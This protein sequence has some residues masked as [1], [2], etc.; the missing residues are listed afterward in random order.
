MHWGELQM[1]N[2]VQTLTSAQPQPLT[3]QK[4]CSCGGICPKCRHDRNDLQSIPGNVYEVLNTT[5]N[6]LDKNTR[7]FMESKFGQDFS[8]VKLHTDENAT[9][10]AQQMN[11]KAYTV[12]QNIVFDN[13]YYSPASH[14]GRHL[15]AHELTHTVQQKNSGSF[16]AEKL[17]VGEAHDPSEREAD[18]IADKIVG[19]DLTHMNVLENK[20]P[21]DIA[22]INK[23]PQQISKAPPETK[24][25]PAPAVPTNFTPEQAEML[26][27]TRAKLNPKEGGIVGVLIAEHPSSPFEFES[28]GGQGFS[29]HIEGKATAKMNELGI[30]KA[31]LVLELEPCQICDRSVYDP[32]KGPE[33]PLKSTSTG[34][35][36]SRQTPKINSAL[37]VGSELT[38]VGPESTGVYRGTAPAKPK[39][40]LPNLTES[41]RAP[42]TATEPEAEKV[43]KQRGTGSRRGGVL[44]PEI[45]A[46][47][48]KVPKIGGRGLGGRIAKGALK[49]AGNIVLDL[50]LLVATLVDELI[51]KPKLEALIKELEDARKARIQKKIEKI[52]Q[53]RIAAHIGK[54]LKVCYLKLLRELEKKGKQAYVN[55][56]L[57][58]ALE[59]TSNRFQLFT[60]TPPESFFDIEVD[61]VRYKDA[62]LSEKPIEPV[63]GELTRCENC[64][65]FGRDKTFITN[66]PLW[67]QSLKFSFEAP[68]SEQIVAEFGVE[69]DKD[70]TACAREKG[71]F[72][73]TACYGSLYAPEVAM[74]RQFRD[75][76]L[77]ANRIGR[78]FVRMYYFLSPPVARYLSNHELAKWFV[79]N[80]FVSPLVSLIRRK[81]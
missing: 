63:A 33:A 19:A 3:L 2:H 6:P 79:R 1:A 70:E 52:F 29:S 7:Q 46:P 67:E 21:A 26:R 75:Q 36:L 38:V 23:N 48:L 4:K 59:D 80:A 34:K 30:T 43:P 62:A 31:T 28:G 41:E 51:I 20:T 45:P 5:G 66:N 13:K 73:A 40:R 25:P 81:V 60:E 14:D 8:Q 78:F 12:G 76:K 37:Q 57:I 68:T 69:T 72:I 56:E 50:A 65:T 53:D 77:L 71:C 11:A 64:G 42:K 22:P 54:V 35:D 32:E 24:P 17:K 18:N 74:L 44:I 47:G 27:R 55:V 10:S 61:D 49:G 9:G 15:L 39:I 16:F 58:I